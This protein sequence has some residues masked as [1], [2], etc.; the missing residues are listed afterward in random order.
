MQTISARV[1]WA[2]DSALKIALWLHYTS[3][4][5]WI[6]ERKHRKERLLAEL[7][8]SNPSSLKLSFKNGKPGWSYQVAGFL[9]L[10]KTCYCPCPVPAVVTMTAYLG[11][12]K[13]VQAKNHAALL[14]FGNLCKTRI[15]AENIKSQCSSIRKNGLEAPYLQK[16]PV[17]LGYYLNISSTARTLWTA[18]Y[19]HTSR[20]I[21]DSRSYLGALNKIMPVPFTEP[22][23]TSDCWRPQIAHV[24]L[25]HVIASKHSKQ[26]S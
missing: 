11:L 21:F 23:L 2:I 17:W 10:R 19:I 16:K 6:P 3:S 5:L 24:Q 8:N 1:A 13:P 26:E 12:T 9:N 20:W 18:V 22:L 14:T 15:R 25:C 4:S 7:R